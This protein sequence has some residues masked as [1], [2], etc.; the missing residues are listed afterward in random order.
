MHLVGFE[1]TVPVFEREK[2]VYAVDCVAT[3][4]GLIYCNDKKK[5]KCLVTGRGGP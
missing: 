3:V 2:T 1:S 4:I 5:D